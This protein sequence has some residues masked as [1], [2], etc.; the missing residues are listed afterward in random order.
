LE[1]R[2][3]WQPH[4]SRPFVIARRGGGKFEPAVP[5]ADQIVY[6]RERQ[7]LR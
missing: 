5:H 4:V 6:L 7:R 2:D 3:G 1:K